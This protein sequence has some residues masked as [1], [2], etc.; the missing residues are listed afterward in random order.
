MQPTNDETNRITKLRILQ[1]NLNKSVTAH[2][3]L[4]NDSLA[5]HW[6]IVLIQEPYIT[7]FSSIRT[8]NHF[9]SVS[10]IS[11]GA[12]DSL[13]QSMIW[14]NSALTTNNWKILDIPDT[15]NVVVIKL[16]GTYGKLQIF[17]IYNVGEHSDSLVVLRQ[18][19]QGL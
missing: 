15:N 4:I 1:L 5:A 3:E 12:L 2:L 8:L 7:F 6:D 19:M 18:H 10:P 13:V 14:V 16:N 9:I 17:S 11:W